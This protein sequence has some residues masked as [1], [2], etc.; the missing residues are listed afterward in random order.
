MHPAGAFRKLVG[1]GPAWRDEIGFANH[2]RNTVA[3]RPDNAV[4]ANR[5]P[6]STTVPSDFLFTRKW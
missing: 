4:C 1:E 6:Y 3:W 5:V 2:F